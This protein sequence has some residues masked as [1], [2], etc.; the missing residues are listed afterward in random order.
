MSP[1]AQAPIEPGLPVEIGRIDRELGKLWEEI[2]DT[3]TRAS[4]INLAIY[5]E[6]AESV[7]ANTSL[8][9]QIASQHACRA[10]LIFANPD[11]P[12]EEAK[13]WISAHCHLAGKGER[14]I[15]S[16]QITFQLDGEMVTALPN[17]VFS[18][19]DSDL[20]LYFWWQGN[21]CEPLDK[22]L[23]GWVDRLIYDSAD[24]DDP[25]AQFSLV[26]KIRTLTEIR[27]ILCDLNWTRLVGA[28]FALAQLFDHSCALARI[29]KIQRVSISC[30]KHTTGLLLLGWLA[31]QLGWKLQS[32]NGSERFISPAGALI[33]F[34]VRV[35]DGPA[36]GRCVF[37]CSDSTLEIT[38]E[39]GSEYF[40]ARIDC[41]G[42]SDTMMLVPAG[43]SETSDILVIELSRGGQHPLYRRALAMVEP[44]IK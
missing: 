35:I 24:W 16:E 23:W 31:A 40:H 37:E 28:R 1:A 30:F 7:P 44:L 3:K 26:Q 20:P 6:S 18:H 25:A 17:I 42:I 10:L 38:R 11:G 4:L 41:A 14:Q 8:I 2:G 32:S 13:A 22:K 12:Q 36:V 29:D 39:P 34:E 15:C 43:K 5:T 27:T 9:S 21:F 33:D 19:L